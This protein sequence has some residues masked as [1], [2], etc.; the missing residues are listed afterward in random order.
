MKA[1]LLVLSF[2]AI[3]AAS[4]VSPLFLADVARLHGDALNGSTSD[5][6]YYV[7]DH[8]AKTAVSE[9]DWRRNRSLG[10]LM[11]TVHP[12]GMLGL[13]YV[14]FA[15]VFPRVV[16]RTPR[17]ERDARV[18][19][20]AASGPALASTKCAGKFRWFGMSKAMLAAEVHAGGL[21]LRPKFMGSVAIRADE[22]RSV[23]DE[24]SFLQRFLVIEHASSHVV[25]PIRL[26]AA[27]DAAFAAALR[28]LVERS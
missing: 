21:V 11:F 18:R 13:A 28:G 24:S 19:D 7:S 1:M 17:E 10:I 20:V 23:R 4:I 27:G 12:L 15:V 26:N 22:I 6:R 2:A 8:G 14:L 16:Y 9:Q 3:L 5:G 25:S